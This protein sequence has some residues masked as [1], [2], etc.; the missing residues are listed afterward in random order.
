MIYIELVG[1]KKRSDEMVGA[2]QFDENE[3]L[4]KAVVLFWKKGFAET[5]MHELAYATGVQRGFLY[6]AYK[7]KGTLFLRV[8]DLYKD[9]S[10]PSCVTP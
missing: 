5:S 1:D 7:A 3:A 6:T 8:F 4:E 9:R 2:R 10:C